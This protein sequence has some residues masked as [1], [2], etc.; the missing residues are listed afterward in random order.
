MLPFEHTPVLTWALNL[1]F[2]M[3]SG[4]LVLSFIRL[5]HG[6]KMADRIVAL[7]VIASLVVGIVAVYSIMTHDPV[8]LD[9]AIVLA[10]VAFIAAVAFASYLEKR[11]RAK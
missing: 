6:P 3:L 9:V 2:I 11:G 10:L 1:A 8:F 7:E 5:S 4:G